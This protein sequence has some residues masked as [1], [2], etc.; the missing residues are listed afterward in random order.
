MPVLRFRP[1]PPLARNCLI[2]LAVLAL[3]CWLGPW[4]TR[5]DPHAPD[6]GAM[7]VRPGVGGHWFGTDAIGR[8][9]FAR[10]LAGGRLSLTIGL[11]SSIVA[12]V[13]GL[14]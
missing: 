3:L 10:T 2:A 12:L 14:G 9:V 6:W 11:L 5:F 8:D 4:A 13:I 1:L 7:S